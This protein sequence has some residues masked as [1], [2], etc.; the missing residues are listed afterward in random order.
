MVTLTESGQER[1]LLILK[2]YTDNKTETPK[3]FWNF[4]DKTNCYFLVGVLEHIKQDLLD[5][6]DSES[7][8]NS[9]S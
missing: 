5:H 8:N 3:L 6:I 2:S 9:K 1:T 4:P 7:E